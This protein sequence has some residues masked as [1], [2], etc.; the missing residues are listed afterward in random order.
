MNLH[1]W[2]AMK[3]AL[4]FVFLAIQ[5]SFAAVLEFDAPN[6]KFRFYEPSSMHIT[7]LVTDYVSTFESEGEISLY[8]ETRLQETYESRKANFD[9]CLDQGLPKK[10]IMITDFKG[11]E[12]YDISASGPQNDLINDE[13]KLHY[14][15]FD[16]DVYVYDFDLNKHVKS[17]EAVYWSGTTGVKRVST[18]ESGYTSKIVDS[19]LQTRTLSNGS[20]EFYTDV[21]YG[22]QKTKCECDENL[23]NFSTQSGN[24]TIL[25]GGSEIKHYGAVISGEFCEKKYANT[26]IDFNSFKLTLFDPPNHN[27]T[28]TCKRSF[29]EYETCSADTQEG[30]PIDCATG[31]KVQ[32]EIDYQGFGQN[33]LVYSRYYA[34]K[35]ASEL[36]DN[37]EGESI[38]EKNSGWKRSD[39][40]TI[41]RETFGDG[42]ELVTFTF[43]NR[44]KRVFFK[45]QGWSSFQSN[46]NLTPSTLVEYGAVTRVLFDDKETFNFD[47]NDSIVNHA[48]DRGGDEY[49]YE[50]I[51]SMISKKS[52]RFGRYLEFSYDTA[53]QMSTVT[54][55]NG[56]EI[57]YSYDLQGNLISVIYPDETP[58]ELSDNPTK[59][60]LYENLD[61]PKHLTGIVDENGD[62]YSWY[63]YD[64][65]GK[66]ISTTH[67][68][69]NDKVEVSYV[70]P[71]VAEVSY[72]VASSS[73]LSR[74]ERLTYT[75]VS[76][77]YTKSS[78]EI[79]FCRDCELAKE[80]WLYT[81]KGELNYHRDMNGNETY[82]FSM[83]GNK[84][85]TTEAYGTAEESVTYRDEKNVI[86][87]MRSYL[88]TEQRTGNT[89]S[90]Q[91]TD[92]KGRLYR[93]GVEEFIPEVPIDGCG[94][95]CIP[96]P[97]E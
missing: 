64:S 39:K 66:A 53:G 59:E 32:N 88:R 38:A 41:E 33:P 97:D 76:G 19:A 89:I 5:C 22:C 9:D 34:S 47:L 28:G 40:P 8:I 44:L 85:E 10:C 26:N 96:P 3:G 37:F 75:K 83:Y 68:D 23:Y 60:Y 86:E 74:T 87:N 30:N 11:I 56:Y 4:L 49:S 21:W 7:G 25:L 20:T 77:R 36:Q 13:I 79:I 31:Q 17:D 43:G 67:I 92:H 50:Y 55:Q 90:F 70:A 61:F 15:R 71:G 69:G 45:K 73:E 52:N 63:E 14:L 18:C 29:E 16:H 72:Y 95:E 65:D 81:Y 78:R 94:D 12:A 48:N 2:P 93:V 42:A 35:L 46:P 27:Y 54:D 82:N 58:N 84:S 6:L 91:L 24:W 80:E 1:V 51:D 57:H 62:R